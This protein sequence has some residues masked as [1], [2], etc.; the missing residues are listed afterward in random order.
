MMNNGSS[1]PG[2][3]P[4]AAV[5]DGVRIG[6]TPSVDQSGPTVA[7]SLSGGAH[8]KIEAPQD[9]LESILNRPTSEIIDEAGA[10][11]SWAVEESKTVGG[12]GVNLLT[13]CALVAAS[14]WSW[15]AMLL[16]GPARVWGFFYAGVLAAANSALGLAFSVLLLFV[17]A[18]VAL[19]GWVTYRAIF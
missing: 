1:I 2:P 18:V 8:G 4:P 19:V 10:V 16:L 5:V 12:L 14:P 11:V 6:S 7:S 9:R 3:K 13:V 15:I 17:L